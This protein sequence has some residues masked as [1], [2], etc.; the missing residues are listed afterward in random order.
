MAGGAT[1]L[2]TTALRDTALS[3]RVRPVAL[4]REQVLPVIEPL[5][6]LL[7]QGLIRGT[8]V[9]VDGTS[10]A[11]SFALALA[12]G[13]SQEGSWIA[14]VGIPWLG[15]AAAA[16]RGIALDRLAVIGAPE[17][18]DW[19][20]VVAAL[21]DAIDV[22]LVAPPKGG[23]ARRAP[24][25]GA[26]SGTRCGARCPAHTGRAHGRPALHRHRRPMERSRA[27]GRAPDGAPSLGQRIGTRQCGASCARPRSGCQALTARCRCATRWMGARR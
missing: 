9:V 16:E 3:E 22:V 13:A 26:G 25:S 17:R 21:V 23:M 14:A 1:A 19:A 18:N 10:G 8:T 2:R 7:P 11:T 15:L 20:T 6:S 4:A 27:R 24:L 5:T 12:A